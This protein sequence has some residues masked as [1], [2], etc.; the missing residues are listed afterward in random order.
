MQSDSSNLNFG[1]LEIRVKLSEEIPV[2]D[3]LDI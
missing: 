2:G 3:Y 1:P